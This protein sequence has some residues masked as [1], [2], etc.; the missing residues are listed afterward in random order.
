MDSFNTFIIDFINSAQS[1]ESQSEFH[2]ANTSNQSNELHCNEMNLSGVSDEY[3]VQNY[4]KKTTKKEYSRS[5]LVDLGNNSECRSDVAFTEMSPR[6]QKILARR[7]HRPES[8]QK[9]FNDGRKTKTS[10][11]VP[12][13]DDKF[14][15]FS[16]NSKVDVWLNS[17]QNS[18]E[19]VTASADLVAGSIP[20]SD[21]H[22]A[23]DASVITES[24]A[25]SAIR[26]KLLDKTAKLK[27]NL[28]NLA[29]N[30]N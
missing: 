13:L 9:E 25:K 28:R 21:Q 12:K 20:N 3:S 23:D 26:S 15:L 8:N 14:D 7:H 30:K 2:D 19:Y 10:T 4:D 1:A 11:P 29:K 6:F 24:S 16:A 22:K 18:W 27:E 17:G 5:Q